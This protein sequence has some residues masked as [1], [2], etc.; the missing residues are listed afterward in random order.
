MQTSNLRPFKEMAVFAKA[1]CLMECCFRASPLRNCS[2]DILVIKIKSLSIAIYEN[3]LR[4]YE[5]RLTDEY[6]RKE[7][8]T[9][10]REAV[11]F[12]KLLDSLIELGIYSTDTTEKVRGLIAEVRCMAAKWRNGERRQKFQ[13]GVE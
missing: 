12:C 11:V 5:C 7:R 4:A 10:Q 2:A 6:E 9:C 1:K 8:F 13:K 3:L